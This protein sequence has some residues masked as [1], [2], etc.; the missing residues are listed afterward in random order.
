MD[1]S[2]IAILSSVA[3]F[4]LYQKTSPLF[5]EEITRYIFDGTN[6]MHGIHSI[7]YM[8][9][10]LK[11]KG[12]EW[13]IM[14]DEDVIFKDNTVVFS[15]IDEMIKKKYTVCG[16]R[17]GGM[18]YHRNQNPYLINTF[19]SILNFKEVEKIWNKKE[20]LSNQYVVENEFD[21]D[22]SE[23][24]YEYNVFSIYEPYYC[25]YLW[26][27]RKGKK[28]L[29]LDAVMCNDQIT[30]EVLYNGKSFLFHTWYAR[31]YG[32]NEKHTNR[33][34]DFLNSITIFITNS[35]FVKPIIF[36]NK[37]FATSQKI[38]KWIKKVVLKL[39]K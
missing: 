7:N 10:K 34:N 17:D 35:N 19:F 27:R 21:D 16:V 20:M 18:I 37:T 33:I 36:K 23:L 2:K 1:K 24:K 39:R 4:E 26:L 12:I 5:P 6:G 31:S 3:N 29:F 9:H 11:N 15:I 32:I 38:K 25:F 8:M 22:L 13:L 28:I 14:A 30:N